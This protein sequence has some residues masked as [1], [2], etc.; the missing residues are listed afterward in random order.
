MTVKHMIPEEIAPYVFYRDGGLLVHSEVMPVEYLPL[1]E[2]TQRQVKQWYQ[3]R[4][5]EQ[6]C[7]CC[8]YTV[9]YNDNNV[10]AGVNYEISCPKCYNWIRLQKV[11]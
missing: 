3:E 9:K 2:L 8:K 4:H 7:P 1:F 11:V 10:P 5:K 6:T